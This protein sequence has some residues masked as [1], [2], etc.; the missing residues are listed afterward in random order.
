[1]SLNYILYAEKIRE[2]RAA[3]RLG[4]P[5]QSQLEELFRFVQ[6]C[7]RNWRLDDRAGSRLEV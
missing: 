5:L 2:I 7:E 1:M 4:T 6:K 3:R